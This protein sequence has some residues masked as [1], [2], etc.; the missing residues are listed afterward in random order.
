M[1]KFAHRL[2]TVDPESFARI[3]PNDRYRSQRALEIFAISGRTMS[4]LK[5][6][7]KPDPALGLE[8]PTFVLERPVA[9]LD[10]RIAAADDHHAE[11]RL[12]RGDRGRPGAIFRRL[13]GA[14]EHRLPGDRELSAGETVA[15]EDL[16]PAIVLVTRQ[17]A[18]RQRTWFRQVAGV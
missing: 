7:Q 9:E 16:E 1:R 2:E 12:D 4:D 14:D 17:Y 10:E 15:E 6:E 11:Q 8:F 18:K 3:H 5:A 13:P